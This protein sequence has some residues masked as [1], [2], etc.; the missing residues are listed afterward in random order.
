MSGLLL[1]RLPLGMENPRLVQ[2]LVSVRPEVIPLGLNQVRQQTFA[3]VSIEVS[4]RGAHDQDKQK[5]TV[6]VKLDQHVKN[7]FLYPGINI[8]IH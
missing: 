1:L 7:S 2:P 4:Q 5:L 8:Y 3:A 6:K